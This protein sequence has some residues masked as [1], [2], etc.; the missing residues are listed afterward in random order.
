MK[1]VDNEKLLGELRTYSE[2]GIQTEE[3][4]KMF[5]LIAKRYSEKGSFSGYTYK[6]DMICEA[7]L[8]CLKYMHNF[9]LNKSNPFAYFSRV[10]H[11][12]FLNYISQQKKHSKIKDICYKNVDFIMPDENKNDDWELFEVCGI[13][14]QSIRGNKKKKRK[15]VKEEKQEV[16]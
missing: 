15:K 3:L 16:E 13:N 12:S 7:V 6:D 1:Y 8:T 11:N 4:G 5:L 14:Y 2:T 9:D 10:V